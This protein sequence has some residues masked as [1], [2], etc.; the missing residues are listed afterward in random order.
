MLKQRKYPL[1]EFSNLSYKPSSPKN[2]IQLELHKWWIPCLEICNSIHHFRSC[3]EGVIHHNSTLKSL[4]KG[5]D[6]FAQATALT[7]RRVYKAKDQS[8]TPYQTWRPWD[9]R[10]PSSV[11][12][13]DDPKGEEQASYQCIKNNFAGTIRRH[14]ASHERNYKDSYFPSIFDRRLSMEDTSIKGLFGCCKWTRLQSPL[15]ANFF[16]FVQEIILIDR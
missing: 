13:D 15:A 2:P 16:P 8:K 6:I 12:D 1:W 10:G 11:N 4:E 5:K 7:Q 14:T 9:L 3:N